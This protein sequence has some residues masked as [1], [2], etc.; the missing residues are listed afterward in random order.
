MKSNNQQPNAGSA[1]PS[2]FEWLHGLV[3]VVELLDPDSTT[4]SV[5]FQLTGVKGW[6]DVGV[7]YEDGT[8]ELMQMKHSRVG[9]PLTFSDLV[10]CGAGEKSLLGSLAQSW[11]KIRI[12]W[13]SLKCVLVTNR[14]PG[15]NWHQHRPPLQTFLD[16]LQRKLDGARL[17]TE[18]AW[19]DEEQ[20]MIP[21]WAE[22]VE[23]LK[24]ISGSEV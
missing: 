7:R 18:V 2:W 4:K 11:S 16:A 12:D 8:V 1:E 6:D 23:T 10:S 14:L 19:S 13:P 17:I 3:H 15:N 21:A 20:A 22:F 24:V 9:D 5:A